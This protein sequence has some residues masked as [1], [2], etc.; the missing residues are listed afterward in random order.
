MK[1]KEILRE[2]MDGITIPLLIHHTTIPFPEST[3]KK[4]K[5]PA[6]LNLRRHN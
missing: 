3:T 4:E 1:R 6:T 5:H 2:F